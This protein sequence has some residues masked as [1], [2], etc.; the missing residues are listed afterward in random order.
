MW[1]SGSYHFPSTFSYKIP[2]FS[3]YYAASAPIPGPST[4]KLAMISSFISDSSHLEKAPIFFERI[5]NST[6]LFEL[7]RHLTVYKA[8]IKRL[9]KK[10]LQLGFDKSFG[11]REYITFDGPLIIYIDI[12]DETTDDAVSSMKNIRYLGSSDSICYCL[13]T[14]KN[15][16]PDIERLAKPQYEERTNGIIFQLR[17]FTR[18]VTFDKINRYGHEKL[19]PEQDVKIAPYVLPLRI[20]KGGRNFITYSNLKAE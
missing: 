10:R 6:V 19:A 20:E 15:A 14:N 18:E 8:F 3:M 5:K 16:E 1:V 9:K 2:D 4:F 11:I 17:D 12:A 13:E 7:P